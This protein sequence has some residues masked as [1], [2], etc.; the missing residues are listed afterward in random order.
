MNPSKSQII[1]AT[2][3]SDVMVVKS[4]MNDS[5]TR[6]LIGKR[7]VFKSVNHL[8]ICEVEI[9][10]IVHNLHIKEIEKWNG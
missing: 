7:G 6:G 8:D 5:Y 1:N 4:P 2:K 3:W 9:N 10:G